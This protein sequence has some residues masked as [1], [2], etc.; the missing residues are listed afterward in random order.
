MLIH[1][2]TT[3]LQNPRHLNPY[4]LLFLLLLWM[5]YPCSWFYWWISPNIQRKINANISQPFKK[6]WTEGNTPRLILQGQHYIIKTKARTTTRKQKK[7][8][9]GQDPP[10]YRHK[11][12]QQN[13]SRSNS[14]IWFKQS[15]TV[16]WWDLFLGC[17]DGSTCKL[18]S[19]T[20]YINTMK[21]K[22]YK[23][24]T[25]NAFFLKHF[26]RLNVHSW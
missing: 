21:N 22:N 4:S 19:M 6:N 8:T 26:T 2:S 12:S 9:T 15:Y 1:L 24:I 20:Y 16:I 3:K 25:I 23:I 10:E 13:A 17:K 14:T 7:K 11:N 5:K 18:I